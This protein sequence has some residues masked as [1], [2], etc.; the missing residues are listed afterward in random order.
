MKRNI[1]GRMAQE[2]LKIKGQLSEIK[3]PVNTARKSEELSQSANHPVRIE[4]HRKDRVSELEEEI[5]GLRVEIDGHL[6]TEEELRNHISWLERLMSSRLDELEEANKALLAEISEHGQLEDEL[7]EYARRVE[8]EAKIRI[9]ELEEANKALL[10]KIIEHRETEDA[11]KK[12]ADSLEEMT[13][14]IAELEKAN[15]GLLMEIAACASPPLAELAAAAGYVDDAVIEMTLDGTILSWNL[16]A[17]RIYG[18]SSQ[19]VTGFPFS[20]M[21]PRE[22]YEEFRGIMKLIEQEE[23]VP[24]YQTVFVRKDGKQVRVS[25]SACGI[26]DDDGEIIGVSTTTCEI[27][28]NKPLLHDIPEAYNEAEKN[29]DPKELGVT[30][31]QV[32]KLVAIRNLKDK[33]SKRKTKK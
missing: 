27:S 24:P 7:K 1:Q 15:Q 5:R 6:Q 10:I 3:G 22:R 20:I 9:T 26:K 32:E 23:D 30:G 19:E 16:G 8:E 18:Y 2:L 13:K 21:I 28:K 11:L 33:P 4:E 31:K 14:R 29:S 17:E 25:V 12:S